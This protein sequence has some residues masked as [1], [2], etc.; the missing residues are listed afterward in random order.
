MA[1][2]W[3]CPD[4]SVCGSGQSWYG[5]RGRLI[6]DLVQS[7]RTSLP[8]VFVGECVDTC[9]TSDRGRPRAYAL[10]SL[11]ELGYDVYDYIPPAHGMPMS[12]ARCLIVAVRKDLTK[13]LA[14]ELMR[15]LM[16]PMLAKS[17]TLA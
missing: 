13:D 14:P 12:R 8:E 4:F 16:K 1:A 17:S 2:G 9:A 15:R 11:A 10:N 3:P 5:A 6:L 7:I